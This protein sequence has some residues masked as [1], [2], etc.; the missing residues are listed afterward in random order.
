MHIN[1]CD[2]IHTATLTAVKKKERK[3]KRKK[4]NMTSNNRMLFCQ[5]FRDKHLLL[6]YLKLQFQAGSVESER[7]VLSL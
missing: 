1:R 5:K 2:I 4:K 6:L 7:L 3:K